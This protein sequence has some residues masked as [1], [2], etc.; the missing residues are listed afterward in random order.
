MG[1]ERGFSHLEDDLRAVD[2]HLLSVAVFDGGVVALDPDVLHELRGEAGF[3]DAAC[4][5]VR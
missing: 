4:V 2:F 5:P 3:S 1:M